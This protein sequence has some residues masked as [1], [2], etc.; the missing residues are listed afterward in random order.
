MDF[1]SRAREVLEKGQRVFLA[2]VVENSRHSPGT[3]GARLLVSEGGQ[4]WGTIGGGIMELRLLERAREVLR[5]DEFGPQ[6]QTL[7]HRKSGPGDKSGMICA[8]SQTNLYLVCRPERDAQSLHSLSEALDQGLSATVVI[9]AQ[10][11][12]LLREPPDLSIPQREL[13]REGGS[14]EYREQLLNRRRIAIIG[15]GH[16][17]L[18]LSR[19]MQTLSY[20]VFVFDHRPEVETLRQNV[21]SRRIE[22]IEDYA[23]AGPRIEHPRLTAVVVMTAAFPSDVRALLGLAGLPFPFIGLMGSAAKLAEIFLQL[24]QL[25]VPRERLSNLHAPVGLEIGSSTPE[26]IAVS[27]AAQLLKEASARHPAQPAKPS[28]DSHPPS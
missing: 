26:E 9:D 22:I 13:R 24:Q 23:Q 16:C 4:A 10:G 17:A 8:G 25:G 27:V 28:G 19:L 14:W 7:H 11:L 12:R 6:I 5:R 21:Y 2:L 20:E 18:A 15:G 1:W 3:E